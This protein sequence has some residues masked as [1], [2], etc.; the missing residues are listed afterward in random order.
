ME[1]GELSKALDARLDSMLSPR[2][3][4]HA[5][6]VADLAAALCQKH[7][8]SPNKGRVAGLAH[9]LC[10]E[11]PLESQ[12][13]G[14]EAYAARQGET[15]AWKDPA[16]VGILMD[17]LLHGPAAAT[18]LREEFACDAEDILEAVAFHTVGDPSMGLL[19]LI[20]YCADKIEPNRKHVNEAFRDACMN[21]EPR[22]MLLAV[23]VDSMEWLRKKG[24][25][26][27]PSTLVLYNALRNS[28]QEP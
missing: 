5:R 8:L 14:F 28:V 12:R 13:A 16:L 26:V 24:R 6:G 17:E 23:V 2:R 27:A 25:A 18:L 21:R 19:A 11:L 7:G 4:A 3:A 15:S 1:L 20:V 10:K 9:D 22:S